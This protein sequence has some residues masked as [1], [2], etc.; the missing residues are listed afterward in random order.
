M[1]VKL[2]AKEVLSFHKNE[3]LHI[4]F[5]MVLV[6]LL[7]LSFYTSLNGYFQEL[8]NHKPVS[9]NKNNFQE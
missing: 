6:E 7:V 1:I 2:Q 9:I 5:F 8:R 4:C 3:V